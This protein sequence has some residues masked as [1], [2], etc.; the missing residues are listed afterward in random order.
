ML[1]P[2]K[3]EKRKLNSIHYFD[4]KYIQHVNL[5]QLNIHAQKCLVKDANGHIYS[6]DDN[7]NNK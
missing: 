7:N 2:T 3:K 6:L 5:F 4:D 1:L